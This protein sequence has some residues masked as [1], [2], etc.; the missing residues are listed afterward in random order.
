VRYELHGVR[1]E[2]AA[3][4][5]AVGAAID[6][7]L[8]HFRAAADGEPDVR[9]ELRVVPD[10]GAHAVERPAGEGR[11]VYDPP[12][13]EVSYFAATDQL[14]VDFDDRVR[15]LASAAD[16]RIAVSARLGGPDDVWL[17]SRP[18]LT[19]PLVELLKRRG[20]YSV[21]AAGAAAGGRAIVL[22]GGSGSG[23]STLAVALAGAGLDLLADDMV[24]LAGGRVHPFPD[25]VDVSDTTAGWFPELGPLADRDR[26]GWPKHRVRLEDALGARVAQACDPGALVFPAIAA[27][28]RSSLRPLEPDEALLELAPNVLLTEPAASQAHLDALAGLVR[29]SRCYRLDTGRDFGRVA[30]L[31]RDLVA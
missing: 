6:D 14:Y 16:G 24:F 28:E 27:A 13:G 4:D 11:P 25:E 1:L 21:H 30:G 7:R 26:A 19:L 3:A 20:L 10:G 12:A 17:L 22:P 18:L 9:Y 23:K 15:V 5:P 29:A 31:L 2:V 8:R